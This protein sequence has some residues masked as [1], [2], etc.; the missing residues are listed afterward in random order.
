MHCLIR[1]LVS[2]VSCLVIPFIDSIVL[3]IFVLTVES[4]GCVLSTSFTRIFSDLP[5]KFIDFYLSKTLVI[6]KEASPLLIS[7][8]SDIFHV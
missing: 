3:S 7:F 5:N 2:C 1:P 8:S 4:S 6:I